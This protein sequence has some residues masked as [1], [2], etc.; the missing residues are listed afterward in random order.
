MYNKV[1][2]AGENCKVFKNK[3]RLRTFL[4]AIIFLIIIGLALNPQDYIRETLNGLI[5]FASVILPALLPFFIL[6]KLFTGL[7]MVEKFTRS[8]ERTTKFLFKAPAIS[9]YI[10]FMSII[11]GYPVGTKLI[12]E[13]YNQGLLTTTQANKLTTF[14]STSGPLFIVGSVGVGMLYSVR[15]GYI[16]LLCHILGSVLNGILYRNFYVDYSSVNKEIKQEEPDI[17]D[18]LSESVYSSVISLLIVGSYVAIFFM[19]IQMLNDYNIFAPLILIFERILNISPQILTPIL[20]GLV[21]VTKGC[22]D[23]SLLNIDIKLM[24]VICSFLISFGGFSIYAQAISFLGGCKV[25]LKFFLLQ[26]FTHAILSTILAIIF[27]YIFNLL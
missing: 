6:T 19:L 11:S 25:N 4:S 13:C 15:A 3:N 17:N 2:T 24:S 18:L 21:E 16:V 20:N 14:C 26:K 10:F 22:M 12:S 23:V 27:I 7:G 8:F 1:I 5:V 9:S